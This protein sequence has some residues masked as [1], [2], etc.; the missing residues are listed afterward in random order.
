MINFI[1][2]LINKILKTFGNY[3]IRKIIPDE[4]KDLKKRDLKLAFKFINF[5]QIIKDNNTLE[6]YKEFYNF[7]V[8]NKNTFSQ[9]YQDLFVCWKLF[10]PVYVLQT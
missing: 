1:K 7:C 8:F 3:E 4:F 2:E 10:V 9:C 6:E 5:S